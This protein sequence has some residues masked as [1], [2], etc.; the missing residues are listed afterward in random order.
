MAALDSCLRG[1]S[2]SVH[3]ITVVWRVR[4]VEYDDLKKALQVA[5]VID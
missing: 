3:K 1:I 5:K 4:R 2:T